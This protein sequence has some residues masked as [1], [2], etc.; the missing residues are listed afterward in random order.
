MRYHQQVSQI[1]ITDIVRDPDRS[2]QP[3]ELG[4]LL[5]V[6]VSRIP[7]CLPLA[8]YYTGRN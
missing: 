3:L 5:G 2:C 1:T 6:S 4:E 7:R 8:S